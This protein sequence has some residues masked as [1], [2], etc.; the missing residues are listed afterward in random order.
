MANIKQCFRGSGIEDDGSM[1]LTSYCPLLLICKSNTS[2]PDQI[3]W[4]NPRPSSTR[5]C[6]PIRFQFAKES[7]ELSVQ[8]ETYFKNKINSL[9][10]SPFTHNGCEIKVL[11]SLQLTMVDGKV[12]SA[13]SDT[14]CSRLDFKKWQARSSDDKTLLAQKK[15]HVQQQFKQRLGLIVDKPRSGG[16]GTSN[17]GNTAR[18][19]ENILSMEIPSWIINPFD[20]M[21]V[22]NVIL[23]EE[24]LELS[25]KEEL[26]V[27]FKRGY[28]KFWL[29][30][31]IPEKY[32]GLHEIVQK[33]LIA[34]SSS[35]LVEQ[36]F[37]AVTNLLTKKGAD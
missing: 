33:L 26:K 9:Q 16:S 21:E 29:Q 4:K 17:D 6:R 19:F 13:L 31:D 5:Y 11:H 18:R 35:F 24:L 23:Q 1:F 30:A 12:C 27:T 2:D 7:K 20:E 14:S 34:F 32:P 22:K 15:Q 25:I 8:E 28:Q 3:V 37:N 36:S 10:P